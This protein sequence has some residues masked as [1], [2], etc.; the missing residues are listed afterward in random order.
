[1]P[2]NV[3]GSVDIIAASW[4]ESY[5]LENR[6]SLQQLMFSP[7]IHLLKSLSEFKIS[8][9]SHSKTRY[10]TKPIAKNEVHTQSCNSRDALLH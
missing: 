7:V 6:A 10:K 5:L 4:I 1:M 2:Q 8:I 3:E 9:N